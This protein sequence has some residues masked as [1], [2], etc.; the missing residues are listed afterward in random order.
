M[1]SLPIPLLGSDQT[2]LDLTACCAAAYDRIAAD[3]AGLRGP[4]R[5]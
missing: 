5:C 1:P 3:D 4:R 2:R